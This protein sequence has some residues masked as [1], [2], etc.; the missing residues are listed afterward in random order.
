MVAL[1][2][3]VA[4]KKLVDDI[5]RENG[6]SRSVLAER[7]FIGRATLFSWLSGSSTPSES[8]WLLLATALNMSVED[9]TSKICTFDSSTNQVL[10]AARMKKGWSLSKLA[11]KSNVSIATITAAS[12]NKPIRSDAAIRIADALEEPSLKYSLSKKV[13]YM[14]PVGKNIDSLRLSKGMSVAQV[15]SEIGVSRQMVSAWI[16]GNEKVPGNRVQ[17]LNKLFNADVLDPSI[18]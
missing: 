18:F 10:T 13:P 12:T 11:K 17:Q 9:L 3:P 4:F 16:R 14:N 6:W 8:S 5:S 7:A 2:D 1:V 15:A